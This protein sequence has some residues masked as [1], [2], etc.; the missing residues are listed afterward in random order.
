VLLVVAAWV[1][2]TLAESYSRAESALF[3]PKDL[4]G[5]VS[6]LGL[7]VFQFFAHSIPVVLFGGIL[8]WWVGREISGKNSQQQWREMMLKEYSELT[9]QDTLESV[10]ESQSRPQRNSVTV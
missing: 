10:S 6:G 5:V 9:G 3:I 4:D 2:L 7:A 8:F 1:S